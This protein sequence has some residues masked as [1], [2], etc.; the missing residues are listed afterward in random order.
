MENICLLRHLA[1]GFGRSHVECLAWFTSKP[2]ERR[3]NRV[4]KTVLHLAITIF[5]YNLFPLVQP[6]LTMTITRQ[7]L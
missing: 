2:V 5:W 4:S 6:S 7:L 1:T 3:P